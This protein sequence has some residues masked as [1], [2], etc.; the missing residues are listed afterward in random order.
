[1]LGL[2]HTSVTTN[3]SSGLPAV[4]FSCLSKKQSMPT[5][6][7]KLSGVF[8]QVKFPDP[9]WA[10]GRVHFRAYPIDESCLK[11]KEDRR[12]EP[13]RFKVHLG[14][15]TRRPATVA[16]P[17]P[18]PALSSGARLCKE[19]APART[20]LRVKRPQSHVGSRWL[21]NGNRQLGTVG[22]LSG[23]LR[24]DFH[25]I[26]TFSPKQCFGGFAWPGHKD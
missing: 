12:T 14:R 13:R 24:E 10:S 1:M 25:R 5:T 22:P 21:G 3:C 9:P 20:P 4:W 18:W 26:V 7:S 17:P 16:L 8:L 15:L 19:D 6:V 23:H 2:H 11:E